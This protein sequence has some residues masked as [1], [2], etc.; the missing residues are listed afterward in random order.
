M[1][2]NLSI[3]DR[4]GEKVR[5]AF[6]MIKG[7][8]S[9][10]YALSAPITE[11]NFKNFHDC[12]P[13]LDIEIGFHGTCKEVLDSICNFGMLDPSNMNYKVR[14]GNV[15]GKGIYVSPVLSY[16]Q[17]YDKGYLLVVLFVRGRIEYKA[18][19]NEALDGDYHHPCKQIMV[20]RSTTQ[21]LPIFAA[22]N[23]GRACPHGLDDLYGKIT[24]NQEV[25]DVAKELNE[26]DTNVNVLVI[27]NLLIRELG[28]NS[29]STISDEIKNKIVN[30]L[31]EMDYSDR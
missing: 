24:H 2:R 9:D 27:Y 8:Y 18:K 21:V 5:S 17:G 23:R 30:L 26:V 11:F 13:D 4:L 28:I 10:I 1:A 25:M 20:L 6:D 29:N 22:A 15:Y 3:D 12:Y 7:V 14:N 16:A 19:S 31:T